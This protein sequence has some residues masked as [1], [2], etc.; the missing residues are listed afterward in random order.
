MEEEAPCT[1]LWNAD[2]LFIMK[3]L[4][5]H[6]GRR[7]WK[8]MSRKWQA[9]TLPRFS[10]VRGRTGKNHSR[11]TVEPAQRLPTRQKRA[12]RPSQRLKGRISGCRLLSRGGD[13]AG[14]PRRSRPSPGTGRKRIWRLAYR[15]SHVP[16]C[17]CQSD[18]ARK[19]ILDG[20]HPICL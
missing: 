10:I 1:P 16:P 8:K 12:K 19:P 3:C 7:R 6:W 17:T 5:R 13:I 4:Q 15:L 20:W 18:S 2:N 11:A 14:S 9:A